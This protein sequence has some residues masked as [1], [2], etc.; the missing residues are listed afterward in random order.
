MMSTIVRTVPT[1]V[2]YAIAPT[3]LRFGGAPVEAVDWANRWWVSGHLRAQW[4]P[5]RQAH[6]LKWIAPHVEGPAG[7]PFE[8]RTYSVKGGVKV[9]Q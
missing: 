7:K 8:Q 4:Y 5:S 9:Y 6:S 1:A 2:K 3:G